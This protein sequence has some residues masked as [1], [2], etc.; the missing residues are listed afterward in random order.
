MPD[1]T[2]HTRQCGTVK[3]FDY[4]RGYGFI[5]PEDGGKDVFVHITTVQRG[6][7]PALEEGA[8]LSYE[9]RLDQRG[10]GPQAVELQLLSGDA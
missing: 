10:R 5:T 2:T 3:F 9:V 7:I 6:G 8:R 1:D 4:S